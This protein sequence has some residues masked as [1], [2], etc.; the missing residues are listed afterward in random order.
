MK[1]DRTKFFND[2]K[3]RFGKITNQQTVDGLNFLLDKIENDQDFT[4]LRQ[5]A[6]VLATVKAETGI[7]Q[8]VK[9]KR[10]SKLKQP[11]LWATQNKY[12]SSNYM[13]RGYVQIT[14]DYNY[15]KA[16]KKLNGV[17]AKDSGAQNITISD[18]TFL[19]NPDLVMQPTFAYLIISRGMREGWFT[20]KKLGDY[21]KENVSPDYKG[22]RYIVNGQD[23]AAE[24]AGYAEKFELILRAS[25]L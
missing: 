16:G 22:A 24:I 11:K 14:W 8:P 4:I 5:V 17:T 21:I 18:K 15:L 7:F 6:Y 1:F 3:G 23:R 13:G 12:W 9:E 2:Y 25:K 10:A 20:G 19:N